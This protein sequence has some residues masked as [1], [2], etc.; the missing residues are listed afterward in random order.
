M[1]HTRRPEVNVKE[2][3]VEKVKRVRGRNVTLRRKSLSF[4]SCNPSVLSLY[5]LWLGWIER[6]GRKLASGRKKKEEEERKKGD[7]QG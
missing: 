2:E 7:T 5:G 3:E 1:A 4:F 6:E